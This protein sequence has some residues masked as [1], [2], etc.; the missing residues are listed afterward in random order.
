MVRVS[1][2]AVVTRLLD[3]AIRD[4]NGRMILASSLRH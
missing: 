2:D 3:A 1:R 4:L